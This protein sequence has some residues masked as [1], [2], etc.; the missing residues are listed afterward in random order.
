MLT[1][2]D[3]NRALDRL[4]AEPFIPRTG[5]ARRRSGGIHRDRY[6]FRKEAEAAI[7]AVPVEDEQTIR[8]FQVPELEARPPEQRLM[9]AVLEE[10]LLSYQRNVRSSRQWSRRRFREAEEW[11]ASDA[12]TWPFSFVVICETLDLEPEDIRAELRAWRAAHASGRVR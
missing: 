6:G 7:E 5:R 8:P 11:F 9:I 12:A 4:G 3:I 2:T 1:L 10:A